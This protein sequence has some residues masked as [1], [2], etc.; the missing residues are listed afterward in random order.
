MQKFDDLVKKCKKYTRIVVSGPQRSGT[1]YMAK[2][3]S[4]SLNYEHADEYSFSIR[5][6]GMF[7]QKLDKENIVIQAPALTHILAEINH[8]RTLVIWMKRDFDDVKRS[9][10]RIGWHPK[11]SSWEFAIYLQRFVNHFDLIRS[12]DRSAPMKTKIFEDVQSPKMKVDWLY[13]DYEIAES[14]PNY[15]KPENR[16]NFHSKQTK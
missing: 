13:V 4:E 12:F 1:T 6:L 16:K 7:K 14:S 9:E 11:D 2:Q 10:D 5:N 15:I 3:L 8:P